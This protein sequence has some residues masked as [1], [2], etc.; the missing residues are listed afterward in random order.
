MYPIL[1]PIAMVG[2]YD[3]IRR[4]GP[5]L[6]LVFFHTYIV[7]N[8]KIYSVSRVARIEIHLIF[9]IDENGMLIEI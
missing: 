4:L 5:F 7:N 9:W 3:L 6:T 8:K 2:F 1:C